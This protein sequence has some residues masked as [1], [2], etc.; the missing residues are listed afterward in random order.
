MFI[1]FRLFFL[2]NLHLQ[3]RRE[4]GLRLELARYPHVDRHHP[5]KYL[6]VKI[7]HVETSAFGEYRCAPANSL[8]DPTCDEY[9]PATV[10]C[11]TL[12]RY[13]LLI[14]IRAFPTDGRTNVGT[15]L[16]QYS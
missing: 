5:T 13:S 2:C 6:S 11:M 8:G 7:P 3:H 1:P 12:Y 16:L 10:H 14:L 9:S 15:S 4:N